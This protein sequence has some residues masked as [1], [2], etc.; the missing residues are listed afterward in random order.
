MSRFVAEVFANEY[1]PEGASEVN[2]IVT[3]TAGGDDPAVSDGA[4]AG[5]GMGSG[6]PAAEIVIIDTSGSM[7]DPRSKLNAAQ[8]AT[9][10]A[11]EC[12]RD[13]VLF[14][15]VAGSHVALTV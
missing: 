5:V 10:A 6:A 3:V 15:V 7:A 11:V 12:I 4:V 14:A 2:A 8:Q 1:L 9:A 13:G